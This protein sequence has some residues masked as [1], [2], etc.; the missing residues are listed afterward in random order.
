MPREQ[1][2]MVPDSGRV[3]GSACSCM[4]SPLANQKRASFVMQK[5]TQIGNATDAFPGV[6]SDDS[7]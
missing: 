7:R 6:N 3:R 5:W 1:P 4:I 2:R